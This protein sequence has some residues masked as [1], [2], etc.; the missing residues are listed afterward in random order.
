MLRSNYRQEKAR[1]DSEAQKIITNPIISAVYNH[2]RT[3]STKPGSPVEAQH[4]PAVNGQQIGDILRFQATK[5][6]EMYN[7]F[8]Q[9]MGLSIDTTI[10][11]VSNYMNSDVKEFVRFVRDYLLVANASPDHLAKLIAKAYER[12]KTYN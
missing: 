12:E 8:F 9:K 4:H 7:D 5:I 2:A 10:D 6:E 1:I 3:N 11:H